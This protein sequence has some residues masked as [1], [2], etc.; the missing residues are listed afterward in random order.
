MKGSSCKSGGKK[1]GSGYGNKKMSAAK[2]GAAAKK[3]G[4]PKGA[5]RG[6]MN[7]MK[8]GGRGA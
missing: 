7:S 6:M 1:M 5:K 3:T 4:M 2:A 8:S